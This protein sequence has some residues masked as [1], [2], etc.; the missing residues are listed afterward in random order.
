MTRRTACLAALAALALSPAAFAQTQ[1]CCSPPSHGPAPLLY[2]RLVGPAGSRVTLFQ[3][4]AT[5][6][7]F[8]TPAVVGLRPGYSYRIMLSNVAGR[9]GLTLFPT[10]EVRDSLH[11]PAKLSAANHPATLSID[12]DDLEAIATGSMVTKLVYLEHP[13]RA[14]PLASNPN[15]SMQT[16]FPPGT[17]LCRE[18]LKRGRPMILLHLGER[19]ATPEA[20]AAHNVP[21]TILHPGDRS[22][23]GPPARPPH[24]PLGCLPPCDPMLGC[25]LPEEECFHDGGDRGAKAA[26]TSSGDLAGIDPE[27]T[28][29]TFRDSQGRKSV[30][31]SNRVC[32]CVPRFLA[33][34]SE[35][36]VLGSATVMS[37]E[38]ATKQLRHDLLKQREPIR[39]ASRSEQPHGY[40]GRK[41]PAIAL[42]S[43]GPNE[44]VGLKVLEAQQLNL[45]LI[46]YVWSRRV[47]ELTPVQKVKLTQQVQYA[48]ETIGSKRPANTE[49]VTITSVVGRVES[50]PQVVTGEVETRDLTV[51]CHETPTLP[52]KPLVLVKCADKQ[53]ANVG[54]VITF[55][56]RYS[57]LGGRPITDVA[58]TDSLSGRLEYVEGSA[59]SDRD[60]VFTMQQ[61]EAGSLILR[62]EVSGTLQPGESGRVRFQAKVR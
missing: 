38:A 48:K 21:G 34:R 29:G 47:L 27:D 4:R 19:V 5:P 35:C 44:L 15:E 61:N 50:G 55:S 23:G 60:A 13:D 45:G 14:E 26:I 18:A 36:P 31:C 49:Q 20:L 51:C 28:V 24:F 52:E 2:V 22:T 53:A 7:A 10:I 33:L 40:D 62:W 37:A 6:R 30:V 46:E 25:K 57:N 58:V 11:L 16:N 8:A 1:P 59:Q 39:Q 17:D 56:L 43:N 9:E 12:E 42:N 41:R 54:D 3:G 32:I